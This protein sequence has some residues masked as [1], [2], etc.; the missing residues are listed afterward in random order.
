MKKYASLLLFAL[1]LNGCDDGN[2]TVDTINFEDVSSASCPTTSTTGNTLIYKINEKE[3]LL[4]QLPTTSIVN[5]SVTNVY[6]IDNTTYRFLYR[7]YDGTVATDNLCNTIPPTTPKVIEE[8]VAT[9]GK[10]NII[11]RQ[12]EV[13]NTTDGSSKISGYEHSI[14]FT[15]ITF[16]KPSG[17]PQTD[18]KFAFGTYATSVTIPNSLAFSNSATENYKAFQCTAGLNRVYNYSPSFYI[19]IDNIDPN[20]IQPV[21]T[22]PNQPRTSLI[23]ASMNNVYYRTAT[24]GTGSFTDS[25]FCASP[26]PASPAIGEDWSGKLGV[27]NVS[28]IIE[29]STLDATNSFI[30]TITLKNVIMQKGG[31]HFKLGTTFVLGTLTIAK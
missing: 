24:S 10:M 19:S 4:L 21:A 22:L 17:V 30:H 29:V 13:V 26:A 2:L 8:W 9:A 31:S 7:S 16:S 1:L 11:S 23:T 20:L 12:V 27:A 28:G 15:N 3:A 18:E 5:D 6:D 25:Y 14:N